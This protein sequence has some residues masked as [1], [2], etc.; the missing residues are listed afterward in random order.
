MYDAFL[1]TP[2]SHT[3]PHVYITVVEDLHKTAQMYTQR[4]KA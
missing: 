4:K 1:K 2:H 3:L